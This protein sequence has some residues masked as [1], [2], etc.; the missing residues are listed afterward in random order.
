VSAECHAA[1]QIWPGVND[2]EAA[3]RR[4]VRPGQA[5]EFFLETL[6]TEVDVQPG[7]ILAKQNPNGRH[8]VRDARLANFHGQ[9]S[10]VADRRMR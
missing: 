10:V 5:S 3:I 7:C 2:Q 4:G 1:A 9:A 6:K 8:F